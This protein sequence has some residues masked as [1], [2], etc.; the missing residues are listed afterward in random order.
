VFVL[1]LSDQVQQSGYRKLESRVFTTRCEIG[2]IL[3]P[4]GRADS[5]MVQKFNLMRLL[6]IQLKMGYIDKE[7]V[8]YTFMKRYPPMMRDTVTPIRKVEVNSIPYLRLYEDALEKNPK[9]M[10]ERVYPAYWQQEPLALTLAKKQYELMKKG[11]S[12]KDAYD[13]AL[14]YTDQLEGRAYDEMKNIIEKSGDKGFLKPLK[15]DPVFVKSMKKF[16]TLFSEIEYEDLDVRDQGEIDYILQT[17]VL[18]WNEVERERRMKDPEFVIQFKN[19]LKATFPKKSKFAVLREPFERSITKSTLMEFFNVSDTR[20]CTNEPFYYDDYLYYFQRAQEEPLL[21][22]WNIR[23][24]QNFSR[25][26]TDTLAIRE[27]VE[28]SLTSVV[29]RYLDDLRAQFFPMIRYPD[30]AQSF[31]LPSTGT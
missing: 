11:M 13:G 24:R 21:G 16:S 5:K 14:E 20:L 4:S 28:R 23:D 30:R 10:D 12:E 1:A 7:P 25:W 6:R 2:D 26:I 27:I 18:K 3:D 19:L 8:S 22:R 17:K 15:S 31:N 9:F 29:Q